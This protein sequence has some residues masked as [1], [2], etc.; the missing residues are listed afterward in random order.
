M[1]PSMP[2]LK[3]QGRVAPLRSWYLLLSLFSLSPFFLPLLLSRHREGG[4]KRTADGAQGYRG[5]LGRPLASNPATSMVKQLGPLRCSKGPGKLSL[6][7]PLLLAHRASCTS[8]G[9][10]S[11]IPNGPLNGRGPA[12]KPRVQRCKPLDGSEPHRE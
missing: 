6:S 3:E 4:N 9:Y 11:R 8:K 12:K 2:W 5:A 1:N 10:R 7:P